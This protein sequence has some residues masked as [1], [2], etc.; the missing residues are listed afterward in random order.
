MYKR[1]IQ[2]DVYDGIFAKAVCVFALYINKAMRRM[3]MEVK[4][5]LE[6]DMPDEVHLLA[7][8]IDCFWGIY[9][10]YAEAC[11]GVRSENEVYENILHIANDIR[12]GGDETKVMLQEAVICC[13]RCCSLELAE[14]A[15]GLLTRLN[16]AQINNIAPRK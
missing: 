5:K 3:N 7:A 11:E 4:E 14:Q 2:L 6:A 8:E 10:L 13:D 15:Q 1:L 12:S 9:D 16:D